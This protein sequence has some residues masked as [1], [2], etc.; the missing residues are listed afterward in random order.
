MKFDC[1]LLK[2]LFGKSKSCMPKMLKPDI[3]ILMHNSISPNL[4]VKSVSKQNFGG[5]SGNEC[6]DS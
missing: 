5:L 4:Q 6:I 3:E 1:L 2:H